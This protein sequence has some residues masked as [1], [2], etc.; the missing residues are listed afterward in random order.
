M[1]SLNTWK[2]LFDGKYGNQELNILYNDDIFVSFLRLRDKTSALIQVY[3][4]FVVKGEI[5][6]FS[7]TLPYPAIVYHKHIDV[8]SK[9]NFKYL[10]LHTETELVDLNTLS[11]HVDKKITELN[12]MVSSV[13]SITKSYNV[14][15]ISLKIATEKEN[16][17]F[18]SDPEVI[19]SLSNMPLSLDFK[20]STP[21]DKLILGKKKE[22]TITTSLSNL[23]SVSVYGTNLESRLFLSKI[24]CEN[25]LLSSKT[26]IV[27]D[28]INS[29]VSLGYPQQNSDILNSFNLDM[30][31]FGFPV[32]K[33][34]YFDIK[35]PVNKI[36]LDAFIN[37]FSFKDVSVKII[38][39]VYTNKIV[40]IDDLI[41][42]IKKI[43]INPEINEFEKKRVLSKLL[44][45]NKKYS[46]FFGKTDV[47]LLFKQR[48][49]NIGSVKVISINDKDLI[50]P[51]FIKN[52]VDEISMSI[53]DEVLLVFPELSKVF[54]NIFLGD[55]ILKTIK[56]NN[57]LSSLI[58]SK[59]E[60]DFMSNEISSVNIISIKNNDAVI[61]Y[62][63]RD[64]IRFLFRPTFTS[65]T[66]KYFLND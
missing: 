55:E 44:V 27:F 2:T 58:T 13:I 48:Y 42:N 31:A 63:N 39:S 10:L 56:E 64:P 35:M 8:G 51:Y 46:S 62:P 20:S 28:T 50:Y 18:F 3:K 21:L 26:V 9:N 52:L 49:K 60:S 54:N 65:S 66:I 53:R 17:Y 4:V 32:R 24:I 15:L 7:S 16:T 23:K 22:V 47:S 19:K 6:T 30:D 43:P 61:Y 45:F 33:I 37:L 59:H 41:E 34:D 36:P 25:F 1:I 40:T 5:E 57:L 29:Y 38:T 11:Y 14:K 12:K